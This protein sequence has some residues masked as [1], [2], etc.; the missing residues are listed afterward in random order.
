MF[1]NGMATAGKVIGPAV[2]AIAAEGINAAAEFQDQI[3]TIET[4][5]GEGAVALHG[6][7]KAALQ[8]SADTGKP[9][10][11]LTAGLYDLVSAG[12]P[13]E[14]AISVLK[15]STNL[16]IGGLGS[17]ADA[18]DAVTS[19]MNAYGQGT[20]S[21][22]GVT[23]IFAKAVADGKVT[24]AQLGGSI[25]TIAPIAAQAGISLEEVSAGYAQL[26]AKGVPA[27][28]AAT[29]MR[30]AIV[31]LISPN[32]TLNEI[33]AK[34][35]INFAKLA[36]E[37]GLSVA[38]NELRTITDNTAQT[39]AEFESTLRDAKGAKAQ[40][41]VVD[42][43]SKKLGLTEKEVKSLTKAIE[44]KGLAGAFVELNTKLGAG[45]AGLAGALGRVEALNFTLA[46]TGENF[47]GFQ[48]QIVETTEAAGLAA[49]QAAIKM[50][51]PVEAGKR[52]AA[53][54]HKMQIETFGPFAESL[55]PMVVGLNQMGGAM[56]ALLRPATLV[57]GVLGKVFG[58][59]VPKLLGGAG[60]GA[61][62]ASKGLV[63]GLGK[64]FV[65]MIPALAGTLASV[66]SSLGALIAGAIPIGMALL[67]VILIAAL[68]AAIAV[69]ILNEDIRNAV[70]DFIGG[71]L[72]WIGNA[73]GALP[74]LL[75]D[76]IGAAFDVLDD[77]TGGMLKK[78]TDV[79]GDIVDAV[80]AVP[81]MV[82]GWVDDI[83][84]QAVDIAL[85]VLEAI[86]DM[87]GDIVEFIVS[88]PGKVIEWV[89]GIQRQADRIKAEVVAT[90]SRM[91]GEVVAFI[92]AIP[93]RI[94]GLVGS[95]VG[96]FAEV[97][98]AVVGEVGRFVGR[99]VDAILSIPGKILGLVGKVANVAGDA[100]AALLGPFKDVAAEIG[101]IISNI[102]S[103][104]GSV[105]FQ[106]FRAAF[107]ED[108]GRYP[109]P[110]EAEQWRRGTLKGFPARA[111][112]GPVTAGVAHFV[113]ERGTELY[114][115]RRSGYITS[116][117][118]LAAA[119]GGNTTVQVN[120]EGLLQARDKFELAEE[121]ERLADFGVLSPSP[122]GA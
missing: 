41:A 3:A 17:T 6:I 75:G 74:G 116:N 117:K 47:E 67:P 70:F 60:K 69:L 87:V 37:K 40:A 58:G 65:G 27:A 46:S 38:L 19:A 50:D 11:D 92:L 78:V 114:T 98:G 95:I 110:V 71:V 112:G 100:A 48:D 26:T 120:V 91:A 32:G 73:L 106:Q 25:A 62:L 8:L 86:G 68:I 44:Q 43:Y 51:S 54:F 96:K 85:G 5:A 122:V 108:T 7:D 99:V 104:Q 18:V 15:E 16:A 90:V 59:V 12:I 33:Q 105:S 9:I 14:D 57:G 81:R 34:T 103:P 64:V 111:H 52:L 89:S 121:L 119:M 94:V 61:A 72:E 76:A 102:G 56:G 84:G 1:S 20:Y 53:Q 80:L 88:I 49:E 82:I 10:E 83:I 115:P 23:D 109:T 29:Q 30:S 42:E 35:G 113:G 28:E 2:G 55:G 101:R 79:L 63:G 45:E 4:V 39:T 13:A 21:A 31:A 22:V 36:K 24:T 97:G 118:D 107:K 66:G 93:G 77:L